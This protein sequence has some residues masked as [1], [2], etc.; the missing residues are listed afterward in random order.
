MKK[1]APTIILAFALIA[2]LLALATVAQP[3]QAAC[4][5][6]LKW[7]TPTTRENGTPLARADIAKYEIEFVQQNGTKRGFK[8]AKATTNGYSLALTTPGTYLFHMRTYDTG[9]IISKWSNAVIAATKLS[10]V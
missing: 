10:C 3:A 9:G 2:V 4:V 6:A 5:M 7:D 8:T 1:H